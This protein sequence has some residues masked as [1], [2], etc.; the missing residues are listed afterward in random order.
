MKKPVYYQ[1]ILD[2]SKTK[3]LA[4]ISMR[5][6]AKQ[7]NVSTGSL[8]YHFESKEDLLNQMFRYYK[9]QIS[10]VLDPIDNETSKVITSYLNYNF[11][12]NSE[13]RFVYSSELSN[14]LDD[15]SLELSLHFHLLLLKKLGL[16][17]RT[18]SHIITILFGT[19]RSYLNAPSYM[20]RCDQEL[21][22][23]ELTTIVENYKLN[24]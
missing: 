3:T 5:D 23:T 16:Q 21:L 9:Q 4:T 20:Q 12:H 6:I 18:D 15:Q 2:L 14:L 24:K 19:M 10:S 13:F 11:T 8:Y 7:L 22:V 1:A 17:Y